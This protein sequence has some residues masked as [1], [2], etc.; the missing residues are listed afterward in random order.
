MY[1]VLTS[2]ANASII[3]IPPLRTVST[4]VLRSLLGNNGRIQMVCV[5]SLS[6]FRQYFL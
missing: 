6:Y 5:R 4:Q 1:W 2:A 3:Y